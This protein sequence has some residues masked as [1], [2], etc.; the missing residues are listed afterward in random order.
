MTYDALIFTHSITPRLVY[1]VDFLSQY[2]GHSF[3]ITSDEVRYRHATEKVRINYSFH[4]L[5]P[6]EIFIHPHALLSETYIRSVKV[7]C[8][9]K[10]SGFAS[11]KTY[12]AFFRAEGDF[13]FDML[14]AIFYLLSRYEEYL[15]HQADSYGR[16][17]HEESIAWKND[18][19]H[20]PLINIWLE[21]FRKLLADK[22]IQFSISSSQ[23][24]FLPTYDID[25][26]WSFLHKGF[27]R[28]AGGMLLSLLQ[29][30][31]RSLMYR[32]RVLRGKISDPF[33]A[34]E[35]MNHLHRSFGLQP[36]FFF[37]VGKARNRY[38][39]NIDVRKPAFQK[40]VRKIAETDSV[41][42]HPSWSSG[43]QP[44]LLVRE[45]HSLENIAKKNINTSRQHFIRF[46]M[47]V[48]FRR[49][50]E[51][52]I[53]YDHSMGYGSINGF[54]ASVATPFLWYDLKKEEKTKLLIHSFCFMDANAYYEQQLDPE[55]AL[56]EMLRY[57]KVIRSVNG[58]MI[59]IWH[60][61]F[62]GTEEE[63]KGWRDIYEQFAMMAAAG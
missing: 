10:L 5:N 59:T 2:Y 19:L 40:L 18:F 24:T 20:L 25:M 53:E 51:A 35:W 33:D 63:F 27:K 13:G 45:K 31:F 29:F 47:P 9:E 6:A 39:K 60:N 4:R 16:F 44:G 58:M 21:D 56:E 37:L 43:D 54:R 36:I 30:R 48:T 62:L 55:E 22:D 17:D 7:E 42:L 26:A 34:Y 49:L 11:F 1:V 57:F 50:I 8:F 15:P 12:K 14:A 32:I 52:G 61:S 23:F 38:D 3:G 41:G 46:E 28:N